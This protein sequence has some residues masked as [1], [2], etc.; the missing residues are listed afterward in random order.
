MTQASLPIGAVMLVRRY[1]SAASQL[2]RT[3]VCCMPCM[4]AG[5]EGR[6]PC[7]QRSAVRIKGGRRDE[8]I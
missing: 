1:S 8:G 4:A 2:S 3:A 6:R 7:L 5:R